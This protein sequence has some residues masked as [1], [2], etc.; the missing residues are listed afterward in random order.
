[1]NGRLVLREFSSIGP[2]AAQIRKRLIRPPLKA[3]VP[4]KSAAGKE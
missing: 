2:G 3:P 4:P 1:V